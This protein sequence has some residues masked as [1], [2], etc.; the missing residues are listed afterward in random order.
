MPVL[1]PAQPFRSA[2]IP[3]P[4]TP[5]RF[6]EWLRAPL[7]YESSD[8]RF[9]VLRIDPSDYPA[10]YDLV[11]ASFGVKRPR[12]VFD[13]LYRRN[14][15]GLARCW[16]V[17][18]KASGQFVCHKA[19]WP[20]PIARGA[21]A[22]EGVQCG[23][24]VTLPRLERQGVSE[25]LELAR[26]QHPCQRERISLGWPNE[27]SIGRMRKFGRDWKLMGPLPQTEC[28]LRSQGA[29][30]G[31]DR[32]PAWAA[33]LR[34][35]AKTALS[36]GRHGLFGRRSGI[37]IEEIR[38]FDSAFDEVTGRHTAWDGFWCPHESE[39]LNWRYL[40]HPT[41]QHVALALSQRGSLDGYCVV[42]L[43]ERSA[44]L[45]DFVAP[46]EPPAL[47]TALLRRAMDVAREAGCRQLRFFATPAWPHWPL[48]RASGFAERPSDVFIM[49]SSR[50]RP[51]GQALERWQCVPGDSDAL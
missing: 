38:R 46:R 49:S 12:A 28:R 2:G 31:S 44:L 36:A 8:P 37:V 23:D 16:V 7:A 19:D 25:V 6:D 43:E 50:Y 20:W 48:L 4:K 32:L 35:A 13:W 24:A 14:P 22:L 15:R 3:L 29:L 51:E 30:R 9:E 18:E 39:F 10:V 26:L 40:D 34:E 21:Q 27:K 5:D 11:D 47:P 1:D 17:V 41:S 33:G 42:K 45:M